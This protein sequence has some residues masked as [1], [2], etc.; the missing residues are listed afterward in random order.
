MKNINNSIYGI[1]EALILPILMLLAMP[2]FLNSLGVE[3]YA[4]WVLIN[5]V[6][7]S[8]SIFN[9]GGSDVIVKFIS[10]G[11]EG[12]GGEVS[13]EIFSTVFAFQALILLVIYGLFLIM[14]PFINQ[15]ISSENIL[16]FVDILYIAIPVFFFKQ[17]EQLLYAFLRGYEQFGQVMAVSG[18]SK[19]LFL[20]TQ[21]VIAIF[22]ESVIDVFYGALIVSVL[23]FFL[24]YVYIK[25]IHKSNI[26]FSKV[27][28]NT[29]KYLLGFGGW[30]WLSSLTSIL[31]SDSDK[32]LVSW[33][34]GLKTFGFYS[35]G[36]LIFNQLHRVVA[37]SIIWVFPNISRNNSDK[38]R[39]AK[40]YWKLLIFIGVLS[41]IIS[42]ILANLS[43]LFELWLGEEFY[44]N[45]QY[46][47]DTFLLLLPIFT[48][49]IVPYF[50]LLGL[51]LV[52]HKF[53]ADIISLV[54]KVVTL[55]LVISVFNIEEW[56]LFFLVF[57]TIEYIAYS[58]VISKNLPTK[59][60]YLIA[61]FLLQMVIVF[62]R[63]LN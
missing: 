30:N 38:V 51:G 16:K 4:I 26:S 40:I 17:S 62:L 6:I 57:I 53:F 13:K 35:I 19:V 29:A 11:G 45:S 9:F 20:V 44:R 61:I 48:M 14:A 24:Q 5:S 18:T 37:S 34:I 32:W 36:V 55:W 21:V 15:Y 54:A 23:V 31:K 56:I 59:F 63:A 7:A 10:S 47:I 39:L 2:L 58:V 27:N 52:K 28:I 33:L 50:Y 46:Y 43:V 12:R 3:G 60:R 42:L 8:L 49:T 22:T 41:L 1:V 25:L